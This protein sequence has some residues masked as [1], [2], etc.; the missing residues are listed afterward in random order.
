MPRLVIVSNRTPP[1]PDDR[2]A[3]SAGGL[4]AALRPALE[5]AG[6]AVWFGWSGNEGDPDAEP[7][8]VVARGVRYVTLD[9]S[10]DQIGDYYEGFCNQ[11]LWP[12]LHNLPERADFDHAGSFEVYRAV[13]RRFAEALLPL[14]EPD[15]LV[16]VHDYHLIP[17]GAAL[18]QA[19]WR[20]R[21]GYFHHVPIPAAAA[22]RRIPHH[23]LIE[24]SLGAYN[25]VGVQTHDDARR[26]R[27]CLPGA[28]ARR[29]SAYPI[30]IDPDHV[31]EMAERE[32]SE[33]LLRDEDDDRLVFFGVDRLDYTKGIPQRL[34]SVERALE[35]APRLAEAA[36]FVQWTAP[37]R[38]SIPEYQEEREAVEAAADH[39]AEQHPEADVEV[40]FDAQPPASVAA[41]LSEAD[42][43]V[44]S[45]VAD[46]MNLVAKEFAAVHSEDHPGV[47]VLSD[48]C[49]AAEELT[50]AIVVPG[51]DVEAMAEAI[52]QAFEMPEEERRE[53][54]R[55]LR[56]AVDGHTSADWLDAF[57][58]DLLD[59]PPREAD[60]APLFASAPSET[61]AV[62]LAERVE[63]RLSE[64]EADR[65]I[66][67][68]WSRDTTLW[69]PEPDGIAHRLG[70]LD[71]DARMRPALD[72]LRRFAAGVAAEGYTTAV[73]I[74]MGGSSLAPRAFAATFAGEAQGL[75]LLVLDSTVPDAVRSV[76]EQIDPDRTL[77]IVSSKSGTTLE[78]DAL[79]ETCWERYPDGRH[80]VAITDA[81]TALEATAGER[82]FRR[83]FLNPEDVGGRY[84]ALS[85]VGLVP[86]ALLGIDLD[87][88]LGSAEV[89]RL[90]CGADIT[91]RENPGARLG[92]ALAESALLGQDVL[93]LDTAPGFPGFAAWLEQLIA[94]S[95]GKDG[96]GILPII[97]DIAESPSD[98]PYALGGEVFRW[99]FAIAI[100]GRVL[101][102]NPFDQP[103]VEA[104]KAATR[105]V[106]EAGTPL[107]EAPAPQDVL[108]HIDPD[109]YL[110]IHAY[111][112]RT[113][114]TEARLA[115]AREL[116][117]ERTGVPVT[118]EYGPSL[119]HS[120]GQY[121]KGGPR[122]GQFLQLIE[123]ASTPLAIPGRAYHFGELRD[124]Q[125]EGDRLA[126]EEL[127]LLVGRSTLDGLESAIEPPF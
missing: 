112:S 68:L 77:F 124:A 116:L 104:A 65:T 59:A 52:L 81:G 23:D 85:Y 67:R 17:L 126:L 53:R 76:M 5:A 55:R 57:V 75:R 118:V 92:V 31:R 9:L 26:L 95:T 54:A 28:T 114:D 39:L 123:A 20:G 66:E 103:D 21:I 25:L 27:A 100:A 110:A 64:F 8:Q 34:E 41:A 10:A 90:A 127:D 42:V 32:T 88:L 22:W 93:A 11:V 29:V 13:N 83:V 125:A 3:G 37:S 58:G 56:E 122:R 105:L 40:A 7:R 24:D 111:L 4:V 78:T 62:A 44:V 14:L 46:G 108:E 107:A 74:G 102:I 1:P 69:T 36:R 117:Q 33:P 80:F 72:D 60:R 71:I 50:G 18:R 89:M 43:C 120:T 113:P 106:L 86:A 99:E 48:T 19:G 73:L 79:F 16:W 2:E 47:L 15:D 82:E 30:S 119:L 98:D 51:N 96:R 61:T 70:W 84:S 12:L 91:P 38:T 49:G 63:R 45:S 87:R 94:E 6:R 35:E 115:V 97:G 101:G 109:Q 121:H